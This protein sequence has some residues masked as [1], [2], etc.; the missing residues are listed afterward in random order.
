[1]EKEGFEEPSI[2]PR[3]DVASTF[4]FADPGRD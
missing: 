3:R 2:G 4:L 1:M